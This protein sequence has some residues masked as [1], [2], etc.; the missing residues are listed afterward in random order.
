[1]QKYQIV[2]LSNEKYRSIFEEFEPYISIVTCANEAGIIKAA[3]TSLKCCI[4]YHIKYVFPVKPYCFFR[5]LGITPVSWIADFQHKHYPSF[6]D[7]REIRKRDADFSLIAKRKNPLVLSS[8]ASYED[9]KKFYSSKRKNVFVI[10]FSSYLKNELSQLDRIDNSLIM[11]KYNLLNTRYAIICNQF[12]KHKNHSVVFEAIRQMGQSMNK[13]EVLFVMTGAPDDRRN[14][15]YYSEL[16]KYLEDEYIRK[17]V[18][19]LGFID[20]VDQLC[21]M[22]NAFVV[23]QPSLFEG[24]GTVVEDAK[25]LGKRII[26]SDIDVHREQMNSSCILFDPHDSMDLMNKVLRIDEYI[27]NDKNLYS[28]CTEEYARGL[29]SVFG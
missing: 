4:L 22:K 15:E 13:R 10:H 29:I 25:I 21:L 11:Q 3:W 8:N 7:E 12:W 9:F 24:W 6:F 5:I 28:D 23:I 20:R 1:M 27:Q 2:V 17:H 16:M 18:R 26:L 19:I 14:P